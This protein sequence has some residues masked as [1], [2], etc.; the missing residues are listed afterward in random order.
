[1]SEVVKTMRLS[2]SFSKIQFNETVLVLYGSGP[3]LRVYNWNEEIVWDYSCEN[4]IVS[5]CF[6]EYGLILFTTSAGK[7]FVYDFFSSCIEMIFEY[8]KPTFEVSMLT[9]S[10]SKCIT[11]KST[12]RLIQMKMNT[13]CCW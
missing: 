2:Y 10:K 3:G 9:Y 5:D 8:D 7:L 1:M 6:L 12:Y 13:S 4:G 11:K